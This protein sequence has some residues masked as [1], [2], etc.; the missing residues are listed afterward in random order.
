M[1]KNDARRYHRVPLRLPVSVIINAGEEIDGALLN[2][3]P[4]GLAVL[5][6]A[7]PLP[8]DAV[9]VRIKDLDV[10]DGTVARIFPDGFAISYFLSKRRKAQLM[11]KLMLAA[12]AAHAQGLED[13]RKSLRHPASNTPTTCR[14]ADGSSLIV[15][16]VNT[17]VDGVAVDSSRRPD[18]GAEIHV[19]R[20]CGVVVRHT[21]RGFVV[22]YDTAAQTEPAT[23]L[24]RVV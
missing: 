15:R 19:G 14:L 22:V 10:I 1:S 17:S 21:P 16:I 9:S 18:I 6:E 4:G 8:G 12:N 7:K 2:I 5:A 23:I 20:R 3:S 24:R 11:E 13:R